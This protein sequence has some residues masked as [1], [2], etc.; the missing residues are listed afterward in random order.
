[1]ATPKFSSIFVPGNKLIEESKMKLK[2]K[3]FMQ[4]NNPTGQII[5][6]Y[7]RNT[8]YFNNNKQLFAAM[9]LIPLPNFP[10]G[11]I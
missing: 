3:K 8:K 1:M 4:M 10:L 11:I 7:Y 5:S 2:Q 6:K 9:M